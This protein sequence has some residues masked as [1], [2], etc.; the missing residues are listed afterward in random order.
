M[1]LNRGSGLEAAIADAT[2]LMPGSV[3][4]RNRKANPPEGEYT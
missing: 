4:R 1:K 3:I 2:L